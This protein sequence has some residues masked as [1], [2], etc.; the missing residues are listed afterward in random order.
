VPRQRWWRE[1]HGQIASIVWI[2]EN[3]VDA[4]QVVSGFLQ[5]LLNEKSRNLVDRLV[6]FGG[7]LAPI[8]W[9]LKLRRKVSRDP[10]QEGDADVSRV[11]GKHQL[12]QR[13][14]VTN[15]LKGCCHR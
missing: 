4:T 7:S 11:H 6:R 2:A 14:E 8:P 5:W 15:E 3:C 10:G 9:Q 1:V 12:L 13:T